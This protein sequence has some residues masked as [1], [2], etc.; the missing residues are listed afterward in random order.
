MLQENVSLARHSNYNIGGPARYFAE[1]KS[2]DQ[3]IEVVRDWSGPMLII[4]GG[5]NILFSDNGFDGL[6][7]KPAINNLVRE[8]DQVRAGA[9]VLISDLLDFVTKEE[10][11]GL[12]WSGGL[13]GMVGGAIRGNAGAFGG[14]IKD[15]IVSVTSLRISPKPNLIIRTNSE[16]RFGYRNSIFKELDKNGTEKREVIIECVLGLKPGE[17]ESINKAIQEKITYREERQP[18]EYP[19]IG[20]IF[21][22]VDAGSVPLELKEKVTGVIKVDPF[23]VIPTAYLLAEAGLKGTTQGGAM[24]SPKHP[25]FIVNTG[26]ATAEDVKSLIVIAK[27]KIKKVFNVELEEEVIIL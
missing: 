18:L 16:C 24:I 27:D 9:G 21:K 4:G 7:L 5:T 13:P 2:L 25:N 22:N 14:E 3:L 23:P 8:N 12:E 10:L 26:G 20:S 17:R 11:G 15:S 19:N 6:V 1:P